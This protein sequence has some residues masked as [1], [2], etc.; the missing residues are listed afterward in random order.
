MKLHCKYLQPIYSHWLCYVCHCNLA[1]IVTVSDS[2]NNIQWNWGVQFEINCFSRLQYM[3]QNYNGACNTAKS[4]TMYSQNLCSVWFSKIWWKDLSF[5]SYN[6]E[7]HRNIL[8]GFYYAFVI[9]FTACSAFL[10][11]IW[12]VLLLWAIDSQQCP[13]GGFSPCNIPLPFHTLC[14]VYLYI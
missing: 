8:F 11:V 2:T 10:G 14:S 4:C 12:L 3:R 1:V 6:Y 7:V 13:I 9:R 5:I